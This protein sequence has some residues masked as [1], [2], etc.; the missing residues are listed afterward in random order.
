MANIVNDARWRISAAGK[1]P[2]YVAPFALSLSLE[3]QLS[4]VFCVLVRAQAAA[5]TRACC[6]AMRGCRASFYMN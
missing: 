5:T 4:S 6:G 3:L 1:G 2:G